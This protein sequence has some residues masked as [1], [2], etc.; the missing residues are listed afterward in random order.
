MK[1]RLYLPGPSWVTATVICYGMGQ[2][3]IRY[4]LGLIVFC[5]T[6]KCVSELS[7]TALQ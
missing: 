4:D 7:M 5:G 1:V 3:E 6:N 2:E